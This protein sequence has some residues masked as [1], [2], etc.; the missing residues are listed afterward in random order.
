MVLITNFSILAKSIEQ[1]LDVGTTFLTA[2]ILG[3]FLQ[4]TP[5]RNPH[6]VLKKAYRIWLHRKVRLTI[7]MF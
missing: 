5:R 4:R 7:G 6:E 1:P 3:V 2:G